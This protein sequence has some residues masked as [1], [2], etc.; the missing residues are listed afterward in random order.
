MSA[1]FLDRVEAAPDLPSLADALRREIDSLAGE[2][3]KREA[4]DAALAATLDALERL[5]CAFPELMTS[6]ADGPRIRALRAAQAVL[7]EAG[8]AVK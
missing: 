2:L 3:A 8:R 5:V 4:Q 6:Y 7:V 1:D